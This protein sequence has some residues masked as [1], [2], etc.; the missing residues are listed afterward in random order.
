MCLIITISKYLTGKGKKYII[1]IDEADVMDVSTIENRSENKTLAKKL[2]KYINKIFGNVKE[3]FQEK[4]HHRELDTVFLSKYDNVDFVLCMNPRQ[5]CKKN[6]EFR[7]FGSLLEKETQYFQEF[8]QMYRNKEK[9]WNFLD[10]L[11]T[12]GQK[13]NEYL[14]NY[15]IMPKDVKELP[16]GGEVVW[17]EQDVVQD[18]DKFLRIAAGKV[19][20]IVEEHMKEQASKPSIVFLYMS[21]HDLKEDVCQALI[22]NQIIDRKDPYIDSSSHIAKSFNGAESDIVCYILSSYQGSTN[23]DKSFLQQ[24]SRARS[25]L[26]LITYRAEFKTSRVN[27]LNKALLLC[28]KWEKGEELLT[29][30][31]ADGKLNINYSLLQYFFCS[32]PSVLF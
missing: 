23:D 4:V 20:K 28:S 14:D 26:I 18:E 25:R 10:F 17:I 12:E 8:N 31:N 30:M 13:S 9:I 27:I 7:L 19:V 1:L 16:S 32:F 15:L 2:S 22:M 3:E 5:T 24:C 11:Q 29:Y 6:R 21:E